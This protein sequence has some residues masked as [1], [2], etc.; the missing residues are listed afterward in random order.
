MRLLPKPVHR[1]DL[2][3][4]QGV[5]PDLVDGANFAFVQGADPEAVLMVEAVHQVDND[6]EL[7]AIVMGRDL[8][9]KDREPPPR[10]DVV[11]QG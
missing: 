4:S 7:P 5:H 10:S 11:I 3:S 6:P 9:P 2:G 1:S 8:V